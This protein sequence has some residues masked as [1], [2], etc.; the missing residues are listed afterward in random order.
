MSPLTLPLDSPVPPDKALF[1]VPIAGTESWGDPW[2]QDEQG[3]WL[4]CLRRANVLPFRANGRAFRWDT[5][6]DGVGALG[7][8][9]NLI[10]GL[11]RRRQHAVLHR[12]WQAAGDA[13]GYF[14]DLA[15]YS[16]RNIVAH[17]HGGQVALYAAAAGT[18]L[19]TLVTVGTPVRG[20]MFDVYAEARKHIGWHLHICDATFDLWGTLGQLFDGDV[21]IDRTWGDSVGGGPGPDLTITMQDIGHSSVLRDPEKVHLW[22]DQ[23]WL[24]LMRLGRVAARYKAAAGGRLA[25]TASLPA[26]GGPQSAA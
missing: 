10:R 17:S 23:G 9:P 11:L 1:M 3:P 5:D 22:V 13:L 7:S 6:L 26:S 20:D 25:L 15:A 8:I 19:R 18:D 2:W 14:L 24:D 12:D 21:K 4:T 16:A